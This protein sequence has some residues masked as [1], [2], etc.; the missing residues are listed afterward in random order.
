[1]AGVGSVPS[2]G[3]KKSL[4]A[5]LNLVPFIDLLSMCICF[6]LMTAVWMEIGAVNVK[7]SVGTTAAAESNETDLELIYRNPS[8]LEVRLKGKGSKDVKHVV[9]APTLD[10]RLAEL[11]SIL[12]L[13]PKNISSA[14]VTTA[15]GVPYGEIVSVMDRLRRIGIVNLGLNPVRD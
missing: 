4:D 5:E 3:G 7:Q 12:G 15:S 9:A 6:L 14:H 11:Q 13:M 2:S 1:M 10:A 8:N